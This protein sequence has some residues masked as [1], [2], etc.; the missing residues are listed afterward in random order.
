MRTKKTLTSLARCENEILLEEKTKPSNQRPFQQPTSHIILTQQP[1]SKKVPNKHLFPDSV[2]GYLFTIPEHPLAFTI[3]TA[4][5]TPQPLD[6]N[7]LRVSL[8]HV[9]EKL[10]PKGP[11]GVTMW[12]PTSWYTFTHLVY[13]HP[14]LKD[15]NRATHYPLY[16]SLCTGEL[17]AIRKHKCFLCSPFYAARSVSLPPSALPTHPTHR[18]E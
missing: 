1:T 9:P 7:I 16:M 5:I 18:W 10:K 13:L 3:K 15:P 17:N 12:Y 6:K 2:L 8:G 4:P 14:P 11:K